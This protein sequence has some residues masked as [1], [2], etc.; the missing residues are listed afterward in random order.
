MEAAAQAADE[1]VAEASDAPRPSVLD[2]LTAPESPAPAAAAPA[3]EAPPEVAAE[4]PAQ[5][6]PAAE[7]EPAQPA[8][9]EAGGLIWAIDTSDEGPP[10]E[11]KPEKTDNYPA[12]Q[13]M[14][15]RL[16]HVGPDNDSQGGD[17]VKRPGWRRFLEKVST[18]R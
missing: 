7:A 4:A 3:P 5:P 1:V 6:A 15:K 16:G 11:T 14:L 10:E 2:I 17:G 9:I 8:P 18:T 13:E 12:L